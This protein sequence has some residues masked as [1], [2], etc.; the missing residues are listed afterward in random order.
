MFDKLGIPL[1]E[2]ERLSGVAVDAVVDSVSVATSFRRRLAE[3]GIIFCS[4]SE[5]VTAGRRPPVATRNRGCWLG[6]R[7]S[8][9]AP[10]EG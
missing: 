5:A 7:R 3:M 6:G 1:A 4:L 8:T 2:Q 10:R 9:L